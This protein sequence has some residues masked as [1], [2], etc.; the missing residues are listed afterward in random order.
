MAR[1][2]RLCVAGQLHQ[3]LQ[4]GHDGAAVF[5]DADDYRAFLAALHDAAATHRVAV[6]AY[7]LLPAEVHLLATPESADGM[8]LLMQATGRRYVAAFNARHR[9]RGTLWE[10]RFRAAVVEAE[11]W[12][13][14]C[15]VYVETMPVQ[16]G[17]VE[18]A[19]AYPWSS[20]AHHLGLARDPLV[21]PHP[22]DWLLGNTPFDREVARKM[23]L[24]RALAAA[25]RQAVTA[26]VTG[27]WVLGSEAY[28]SSVE[29]RT[30]R[31]V[32]PSRPGRPAK[33]TST[34]LKPGNDVS[35]I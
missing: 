4:R 34:G 32:R 31:R 13:R 6:H 12:L 3:A 11:R 8:S 29:T 16:A 26:A 25:E 23:L 22:L 14:S 24:Q 7:A 27:G 19:S 5:R 30:L 28:V 33:A 9:R 20:A 18:E 15:E 17:L 21:K 10:G 1:L 35:P 2:A